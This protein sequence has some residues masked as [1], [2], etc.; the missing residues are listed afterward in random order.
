[1]AAK[2][3][4]AKDADSAILEKVLKNEIP[5]HKLEEHVTPEKAA[6][7]RRK[8]LTQKT[9]QKL[10]GI[11]SATIDYSKILN[12]N[13]ENVIGA[14]QIPVGIAGPLKINGEYAKGEFYVPMGTTE[15]ALIASATRGMK[16]VNLSGGANVTIISDSMAR[17]P[18][19]ELDSVAEA[20]AF[21]HWVAKERSDIIKAAEAT[22][23]HGKLV[24][25]MPFIVGNNVWLRFS[26]NTGDA[27]G[28]N[29]ATI[30]SEA[31]CTFIT[32]TYTKARLVAVSGNMCSD[33]K[34]SY[35]NEL[36]GRGKNVV[37]DAV[38][39]G[40]V[41]EDILK[42]NASAISNVNL[43]KNLLGS[44]RAGSSKH[45][46]HFA[47]I[48]AAIFLATG[49]D[50]A[51]VVESSSG[52]T[53]TEVRGEDLYISVTLPS[54]EIGTVGGGTALATQSEALSIM[55]VDGGSETPGNN[56]KKFAEII[57]ASVLAGELNLLAA[58]ASRELGKAHS[59]LG[60]NKK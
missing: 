47:N 51:Q 23:K 15:G 37:A 53:W 12:K 60:R 33:K 42:S 54:L 7:I 18:L 58:L 32:G 13:T 19:F 57:A 34:E 49:Q 56:S 30:A 48:I 28:M 26:Y 43:K 44:S 39:K 21:V 4:V 17:A 10:P 16:S 3:A 8:F 9:G 59:Q 24:E 20:K 31:A 55:G 6:E 22:T 11:G 25:I 45:N 35:V 38:I 41:L 14:V 1:M 2:K 46:S 50:P 29:M 5:L 52:Y 36:L 40:D 27:M